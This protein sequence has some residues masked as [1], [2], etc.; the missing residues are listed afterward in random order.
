MSAPAYARAAYRSLE[1]LSPDA[2]PI[3]ANV[4]RRSMDSGILETRACPDPLPE[5]LQ[6][7]EPGPRFCPRYH[8]GF[9]STRLIFANS[10]STGYRRGPPWR[11]SLNPEAVARYWQNQ[12]APSTRSKSQFS[13]QPVRLSS[14][15]AAIAEG[16]S[17]P[18]FFIS[19]RTS[20]TLLSSAGLRKRSRF[21]SAYF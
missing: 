2:T 15:M 17:M 9:F 7:R 5:G 13:R 6:I 10:S 8:P 12:H 11:R 21:S 20:P 4:C 18:S 19:F 16:S 14:L 1:D 3:E